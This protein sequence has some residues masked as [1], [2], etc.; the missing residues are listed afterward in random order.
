MKEYDSLE[1]VTPQS[2]ASTSNHQLGTFSIVI[3]FL[4]TVFL[5]GALI[6]DHNSVTTTVVGGLV[7]FTLFAAMVLLV[8]SGQLASILINHQKETTVRL[9]DR[10]Q[11][12]LYLQPQG[13]ITLV[14]PEQIEE[15]SVLAHRFIPAVPTVEDGV[16]IAC[17]DF[18]YGL[19]KDGAPDPDRILG[20]DTKSPY[21]IQAKKPR[22]EVLEYLM[23]LGMVW[24]NERKMLFFDTDRYPT[25]VEAQRAVKFGVRG[26]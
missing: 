10:Q 3:G 6:A 8:S 23:S 7:F 26:T 21:Q 19:F 13:H 25:L 15:Q 18:I 1:T 14:E 2:Q 4:V 22:P 17:Y 12:S 16:K 20:K 9:R 11:Y 24:S 5:V